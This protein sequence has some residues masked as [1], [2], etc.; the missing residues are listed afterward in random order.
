MNKVAFLPVAILVALSLG[1]AS[2]TSAQTPSEH[3]LLKNKP[4]TQSEV[5]LRMQREGQQASPYIQQPSL[6]ERERSFQRWLDSYQY[7]IPDNFDQKQ[8]GSFSQN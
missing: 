5:W 3:G 2:N 4:L 8:G 7:P 1:I 6:K